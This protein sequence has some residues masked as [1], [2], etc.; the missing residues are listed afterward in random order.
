MIRR[1][2]SSYLDRL[3]FQYNVLM[4]HPNLR[5]V[6]IL[7]IIALVKKVQQ[8]L[9]FNKSHPQVHSDTKWLLVIIALNRNLVSVII[10]FYFK[11]PQVS[12]INVWILVLNEFSLKFEDL[13]V[14]VA[15]FANL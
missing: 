11:L 13:D 1:W 3:Y 7:G 2:G 14:K 9:A 4:F 15:Y 10:P 12:Y 5:Q 6:Y 8:L